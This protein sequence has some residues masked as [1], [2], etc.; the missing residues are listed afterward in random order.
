MATLHADGFWYAPNEYLGREK[1]DH[2]ARWIAGRLLACGWTRQAVAATLGNMETESK[3]NPG[4][5]E[6]RKDWEA[7]GEDSMSNKHGYGLVQWTPWGKY[8]S[9][10]ERHGLERVHIDSQLS[11]IM[12]EIDLGIQW[13]KTDKFP[14]SF[15][16]YTQSTE[17]PYYLAGVFVKN[18]ERPNITDETYRERGSQAEYFYTV[19]KDVRPTKKGVWKPS[20]E[21]EIFPGPDAH[22][23]AVVHP[24][25]DGPIPLGASGDF[26]IKYLTMYQRKGRKRFV[27]R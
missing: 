26:I 20:T 5:W 7:S 3:V 10:A 25:V 13:I 9:Y 23:P 12:R 1:M 11:R 27:V 19:I 16:E 18:Y 6:S 14:M 17:S 22:P 2:N 15:K 8:T 24:S 4:L 21:D